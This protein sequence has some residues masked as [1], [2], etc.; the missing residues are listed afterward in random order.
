[1]R[2]RGGPTL[3]RSY[4]LSFTNSLMFLSNLFSF[5]N[6]CRSFS[7]RSWSST[8]RLIHL[9]QQLSGASTASARTSWKHAPTCFGGH[10]GT[11]RASPKS[12]RRRRTRARA[13]KQVENRTVTWTCAPCP[14]GGTSKYHRSHC[15]CCLHNII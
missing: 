8:T 2:T 3:L 10:T 7:A 1:M 9:L 14:R 12:A 15:Y 11:R 5:L 4:T 13:N 6:V